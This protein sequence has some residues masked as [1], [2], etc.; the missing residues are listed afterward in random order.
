[1][2]TLPD[3]LFSS[4][5]RYKNETNR[6]AEWLAV[7]AKSLGYDLESEVEI[8]R[9][10]MRGGKAR[11]LAKEAAKAAGSSSNSRPGSSNTPTPTPA[12]TGPITEY[13]IGVKQFTTLA[14]F[15]VDKSP[16]LKVPRSVLNIAQS[17]ISI[18][19]RCAQWF[20][21][22][23]NASEK[24]KKSN[25]THGH[26]ISVL[27]Q[28]V[29][30]LKPRCAELGVKKGKEKDEKV[31]RD[32]SVDEINLV[33]SFGLLTVE[34]PELVEAVPSAAKGKAKPS[35]TALVQ[36]RD[37]STVYSAGK[38]DMEDLFA[39]FCFFE[40][41]KEMRTFLSELWKDYRD[42]KVDLVTV[43]V[44]TNTALDLIPR[45]QDDLLSFHPDLD[46]YD[47]VVKVMYVSACLSRGEDPSN[48][49]K[50]ECV[51]NMNMLDVADFLYIPA[52][53]ILCSLREAIP[54]GGKTVPVYKPGHLGVY[55][56]CRNRDS[57]SI[58]EKRREDLI[59]AAECMPDFVFLALQKMDLPIED[60]L[61]KE[62]RRLAQSRVITPLLVFG[63]QIF[64]DIHH[65]LR[66][67]VHRG[68]TELQ[69]SGESFLA[70]SRERKREA[71][72]VNPTTWPHGNEMAVQHLESI[73]EEWIM[74]DYIGKGKRSVYARTLPG[75]PIEPFFLLKRHPLL[76]GLLQFRLQLDSQELGIVLAGAFGSILYTCHL[77]ERARQENLLK[78]DWTDMEMVKKIHGKEAI[79]C[80]R[81]PTTA[82][83]AFKSYTLMMGASPT[84]FAKDRR[85]NSRGIKHSE[86][87]PRGLQEN[88]I[89]SAVFKER[90]RNNGNVALTVENIEQLLAEMNPSATAAMVNS[91]QKLRHQWL[92]TRHLTP[93]QLLH[94]LRVALAS[95]E[96]SLR[97]DYISLHTRC[98]RFLRNLNVALRPKLVQ[99]FG[100]QYLE[101]ESQLSNLVG[102]VL[103][104]G[105]QS[106]RIAEMSGLTKTARKIGGGAEVVSRILARSAE[107]LD[108]TIEQEGDVE[109]IKLKGCV[110]F[111]KADVVE[112]LEAEEEGSG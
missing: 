44:T 104:I 74:K 48:I 77:Y 46:D 65:I 20:A 19:K 35:T 112:K 9:N 111:R 5:K 73:V 76:C 36:V 61:T 4:S 58:Q 21:G 28:V 107:V 83:E 64:L 60:E 84:V 63:I 49:Q 94:A 2:G 50:P 87:G 75:V 62:Y 79:F 25:E 34:E 39:L 8:K 12:P 110:G 24:I 23:A 29:E 18:R 53:S 43:S 97:F 105:T 103:M 47:K 37:P 51:V 30:I 80:G 91:K 32:S 42:G 96:A 31:T 38:D 69:K 78:E 59:I 102:Y 88:T 67:N 27:E 56:P 81:V 72:R 16:T 13:I 106:R 17:A 98:I 82:E 3:F 10:R 55:D 109:C 89:V 15:I 85:D 68:L 57:L 90:F 86:H 92:A 40:D 101:N 66:Q 93:I 95:D 1:M 70:S 26:F 100:N 108:N 71:P 54:P 14:R 45:A 22:K 11:K 99:Y 7:T 52:Y 41:L 6:L 33:N